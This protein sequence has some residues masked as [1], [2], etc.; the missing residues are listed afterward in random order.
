MNVLY[1]VLGS[2]SLSNW[3]FVSPQPTYELAEK[4]L[5]ESVDFRYYK[6]EKVWGWPF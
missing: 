5:S 3:S 2:N 4:Y 6:I 1:V